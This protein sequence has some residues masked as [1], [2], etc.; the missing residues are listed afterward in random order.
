MDQRGQGWISA[1]VFTGVGYAWEQRRV[2]A[3]IRVGP[4]G[5][6][7]D[8]RR[9]LYGGR[10]CAGDGFPPPRGQAVRG[11]KRRGE[12]SIREGDDIPRECQG[13]VKGGGG[14]PRGTP[15]REERT[16][17]YDVGGGRAVSE[18]PLWGVGRTV[19][20]N[21]RPR[22]TP[23]RRKGGSGMTWEGEGRFPNRP[24]ELPRMSA[25]TV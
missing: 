10:L 24:Y 9:C 3:T 16:G 2:R 6:G 4:A 19:A 17:M 23:L 20:C 7:M 13:G 12:K 8:S 1:G 5:P 18:P 22:G 14:R 11:K 25:S 15:L 21:G